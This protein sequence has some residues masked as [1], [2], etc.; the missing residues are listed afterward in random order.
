MM[1]MAL[2]MIERNMR[3]L[4]KMKMLEQTTIGNADDESGDEDGI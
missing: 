3:M 4:R 1:E 2:K